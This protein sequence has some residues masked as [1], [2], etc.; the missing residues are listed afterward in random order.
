MTKIMVH[1]DPKRSISVIHHESA[2]Y[3]PNGEGKF[4]IADHHVDAMRPHGLITED[5]VIKETASKSS[6]KT[7]AEKDAEIERL[8]KRVA[9]LEKK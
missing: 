5:E 8:N 7:I 4:E 2:D 6:K 9:E 1:A 3:R